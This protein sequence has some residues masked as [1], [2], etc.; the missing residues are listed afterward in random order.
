MLQTQLVS[1]D[2]AALPQFPHGRL[3]LAVPQGID[4]GVHHWGE[5]SVDHRDVLVGGEGRKG[6]E[7]DEDAGYKEEGDDHH[8]GGAGGEDLPVPL[9]EV[10][11]NCD[12]DEHVRCDQHQE[13]NQGY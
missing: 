13:A 11:P 3:H 5:D 4:E 2:S 9:S 12:Q 6:T 8:M 7:V 1:E 10:D